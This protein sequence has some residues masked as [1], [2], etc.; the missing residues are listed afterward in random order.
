[1]RW[2]WRFQDQKFENHWARAKDV[3]TWL[4]LGWRWLVT[5][6]DWNDSRN[7]GFERCCV[8]ALSK[9]GHGMIAFVFEKDDFD[10]REVGGTR[11]RYIGCCS[12]RGND[13]GQGTR[14]GARKR[15]AL[16]GSEA[17]D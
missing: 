6:G 5:G 1:M 7:Q 16:I 17:E 3:V 14:T 11:D 4:R 8:L 2:G 9:E 15:T 12:Y 13:Q 10:R